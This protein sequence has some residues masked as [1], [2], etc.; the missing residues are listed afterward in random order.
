MPVIDLVDVA[1]DDFVFPL[2]IIR[3]TLLLHPAHVALDGDTQT[4][5]VAHLKRKKDKGHTNKLQ[6]S[7]TAFIMKYAITVFRTFD[8]IVFLQ[9]YHKL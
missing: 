9:I 8:L 4:Q 3:D 5:W 7:K 6:L 2:H 1:E